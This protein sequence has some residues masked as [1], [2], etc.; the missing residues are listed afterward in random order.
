LIPCHLCGEKTERL[1]GEVR[2]NRAIDDETRSFAI[3]IACKKLYVREYAYEVS[4]NKLL[5]E[6][7]RKRAPVEE[8]DLKDIPMEQSQRY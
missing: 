8:F 3:K 1:A 5:T 6:Y 2:R 4:T 7:I